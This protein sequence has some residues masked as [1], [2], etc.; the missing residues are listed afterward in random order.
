VEWCC[1]SGSFCTG[2]SPAAHFPLS[3][4][5]Y[6]LIAHS[7]PDAIDLQVPPL[8]VM[9]GLWNGA[10]FQGHSAQKSDPLLISHCP[11]LTTCSSPTHY[12]LVLPDL[13]VPPLMVTDG[14]WNGAAFQGHSAQESHPLLISHCPPLTTRSSFTH[15]P[16]I[17]RLF[18]LT[19]KYL[20]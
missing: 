2:I 5:H 19:C 18:S 15:R 17:T 14:L 9:D 8:M 11:P 20:H 1:I 7:L 16:P 13:Q 4:T 12:P 3:N 6:P 10:A